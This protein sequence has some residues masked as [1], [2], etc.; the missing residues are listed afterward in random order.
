M[1]FYNE[2]RSVG[3]FFHGLSTWSKLPAEIVMVDGGSND[4]TVELVEAA[5]PTCPVPVVF[6][7]EQRCNVPRGR[8][9]AFDHA[10]HDIIAVTDMGCLIAP[11]WLERITAPLLTT[12]ALDVV[13]GFYEAIRNTPFQECYHHLTH[14]ER[15]T[16]RFL[17]SSRSLALRKHAWKAVGGY[18]EH[19]IAGEDTLFDIRLRK[20]G[21]REVTVPEAKVYW[22]VKNSYRLVYHQYYRYGR[23][24]GRA[25][26]QPQIYGFYLTNYALL[27]L[28][29]GLALTVHPAFLLVLLAHFAAYSVFRI[30]KRRLV[31]ENLSFANIVRYY[32]IVLAIDAGNMF[33]YLAG[34]GK[35]FLRIDETWGPARDKKYQ[36]DPGN[37]A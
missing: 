8:N 7:K 2:R 21:F 22:E 25:W 3:R 5:I 11:D 6:V 29:I 17:P 19:I 14:R 13:G 18:P 20:A 1:T 34:I 30:F 24:A 31:R 15:L 32:G 26:I 16:R 33:G 35:F 12:P 9:I 23:G 27:F 4:G 10:S 28:W 36:P 37:A